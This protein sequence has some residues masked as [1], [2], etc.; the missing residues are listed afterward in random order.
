MFSLI[1]PDTIVSVKNLEM[2]YRNAENKIATEELHQS[3]E[4][5]YII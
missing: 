1:N 4:W 3:D 5:Y 2:E